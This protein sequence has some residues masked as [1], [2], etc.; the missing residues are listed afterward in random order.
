M[1]KRMLTPMMNS[2]RINATNSGVLSETRLDS[3][4]KERDRKKVRIKI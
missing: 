3:T 4:E 2:S 1:S